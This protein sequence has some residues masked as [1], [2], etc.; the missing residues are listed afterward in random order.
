LP[1]ISVLL[2]LKLE[3]IGIRT[4]PECAIVRTGHPN[5]QV[6]QPGRIVIYR[7]LVDLGS[8]ATLCCLRK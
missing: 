6:D 3:T 2:Q 1:F 7:D 5:G 4:K 8:N